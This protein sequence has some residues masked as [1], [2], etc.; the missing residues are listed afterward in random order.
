MRYVKIAQTTELAP[1]S[2][3]RVTAEGRPLL[4]V[5]FEGT[6]Y[7]LNDKCPHMGGSLSDGTLK[8]R[9]IICPN[10]GATFD[11][12]DGQNRRGAKMSFFKIHVANARTFP[13]KVDG[14]D[15][16]VDLD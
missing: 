12:T 5:N 10:H 6:F 7:A 8:G 1:G 16:L 3:K 4:L 2:K 13:V 11:V 14:T 15:V 9:N